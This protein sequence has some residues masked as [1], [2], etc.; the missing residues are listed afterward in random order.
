MTAAALKPV[1]LIAGSDR[2]KVARALV[3][4]RARFHPSAVEVLSASL[5]G[6]EE[7]VA[8]CNALGLFA[9]SGRLVLVE[10]VERWKPEDVEAVASYLKSPAPATVLCLVAAEARQSSPLVKL[11]QRA[12]QVLVYEVPRRDLAQWVRAELARWGARATP[13][14][15]RLL[16]EL[17]GERPQE[18][19]LEVEK[20]ALWAQGSE[21]EAEDVEELVYARAETPPWA[22]TDAWGRRDVAGVLAA[23]QRLRE[24][25]GREA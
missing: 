10:E 22:L 19:A 23:W 20:L 21:I 2:S 11:C 16:L 1:Y 14:A 12:G 4:L 25:G 9:A 3:R 8:A 5:A 17:V 7:A 24:R 15:C 18:L 6:G 13:E